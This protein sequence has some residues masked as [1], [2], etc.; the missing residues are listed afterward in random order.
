MFFG[1]RFRVNNKKNREELG[2]FGISE[3]VKKWANYRIQI[4][5]I[6]DVCDEIYIEIIENI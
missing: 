5:R 2:E 6:D 3:H 1:P 4:Q